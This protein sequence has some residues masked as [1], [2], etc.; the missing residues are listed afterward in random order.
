MPNQTSYIPL[1]LA[2]NFTASA[3]LP[4]PNPLQPLGTGDND[5]GYVTTL[6][7]VTS[8]DLTYN[9]VENQNQVATLGYAG[10]I[11]YGS[12]STEEANFQ[13]LNGTQVEA[14]IGTILADPNLSGYEDYFGDV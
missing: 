11:S 4:L 13:S 6:G 3:Q 9:F 14:N 7:G 8:Y 12:N 5:Y 2:Q 1:L 10:T